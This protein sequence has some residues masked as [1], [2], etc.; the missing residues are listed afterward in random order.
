MDSFHSEAI[1]QDRL[2]LQPNIS[3]GLFQNGRISTLNPVEELAYNSFTAAENPICRVSSRAQH[4]KH[5]AKDKQH[6]GREVDGMVAYFERKETPPNELLPVIP[7]EA[8]VSSAHRGFGT[9]PKSDHLD[10]RRKADRTPTESFE[11]GLALRADEARLRPQSS[12]PLSLSALIPRTNSMATS[13]VSWS[14]SEQTQ[15]LMPRACNGRDASSTPETIR[16]GLRETGVFNGTGKSMSGRETSAVSVEKSKSRERL[17]VDTGIIRY[18]DKGVMT[19][20]DL[21]PLPT[22]QLEVKLAE[23]PSNGHN[24]ACDRGVTDNSDQNGQGVSS[25]LTPDQRNEQGLIANHVAEQMPVD[26][27]PTT[28]STQTPTGAKQPQLHVP[29]PDDDICGN[30]DSMEAVAP[31]RERADEAFCKLSTTIERPGRNLESREAAL[32]SQQAQHSRPLSVTIGAPSLSDTTWRSSTLCDGVLIRDHIP[33]PSTALY[34]EYTDFM[35]AQPLSQFGSDEK[36]AFRPPL[37]LPQEP[38]FRDHGRDQIVGNRE[39]SRRIDTPLSQPRESLADFIARAEQDAFGNRYK[40]GATN[41]YHGTALNDTRLDI[42]YPKIP[43]TENH[44]RNELA[45]SERQPEHSSWH[46]MDSVNKKRKRTERLPVAGYNRGFEIDFPPNR[47][48]LNQ[49]DQDDELEEVR[50]LWPP[51]L[52]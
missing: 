24:S 17:C 41:S 2:T 46:I 16:N 52:F 44:L 6:R 10:R 31:A 50:E 32:R 49:V 14:T 43:Y 39:P 35:G 13:Y 7:T 26:I 11:R 5:R 4:N 15:P 47:T 12:G 40:E 36:D 27:V 19:A 21:P 37:P 9:H 8:P 23:L 42:R 25:K 34:D 22:D 3:H 48:Q 33:G 28:T 38:R 30:G 45:V 20:A 29:V 1:L 51:N 18:Q